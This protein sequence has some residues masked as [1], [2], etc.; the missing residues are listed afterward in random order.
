MD[1]VTHTLSGIAVGTILV[2]F[3]RNGFF[4][5]VPIVFM[6]ALGGAFPDIDAISLWSKFDSTIG[7]F[8]NLTHTGYNIYFS[9][10]WY[11]HHAFFHSLAAAI[12]FGLFLML[13]LYSFRLLTGTQKGLFA[14]YKEYYLI[15]LAFTLGCT[16]HLLG[17]MPTP[18]GPWGG[19]NIFWPSKFYLG[20]FGK[21]WWWNNYDIFLIV[22]GCIVLNILI[23]V[24]SGY[25]KFKKKLITIMVWLVCFFAVIFQMNKRDFDFNNAQKSN[26]HFNGNEEKSK[27]IQREIL[28]EKIYVFMEKM[29]NSLFIHF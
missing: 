27:M 11:S 1:I 29:D 5:K 24:A 18:G 6:S 20:G 4:E 8:L 3:S 23:Y 28:G 12:L 22:V 2:N 21:I 17:D 10:F 9:K 13:L 25:F 26:N 19:I 15:G 16:M 14:F 7:N